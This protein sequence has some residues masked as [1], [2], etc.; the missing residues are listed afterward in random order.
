MTE[1]KE[2]NMKIIK[3]FIPV[4]LLIFIFSC[5]NTTGNQT[6]ISGKVFYQQSSEAVNGAIVYLGK[7]I[8]YDN[9]FNLIE[10]TVT[11]NAGYF[12][13]DAD[14]TEF[15]IYNIYAEKPINKNRDG[16]HTSPVT[17]FEVNENSE[18]GFYANLE[19][20]SMSESSDL[21]GCAVSYPGYLLT[22]Q[23]LYLNKLE[24]GIFTK[25]DSIFTDDGG[26]YS[27]QNLQ[28]GNY[29]ISTSYNFE[30]CFF[31]TS[32]YIFCDGEED[33]FFDPTYLYEYE[34]VDKPAIYIYP[35]KDQKFQVELELHHKTRIIKS[36]PKY[37]NSWQVFVEKSGRI[38]KK[39]DYLFY[40]IA[41]AYNLGLSAGWCCSKENLKDRINEILSQI[42]L[43]ENE[44]REFLDYWLPRLKDHKYYKM[45]PLLNEE[46]DQ[47]VE[48]KITPEPDSILRIFLFFKG[49]KTFENLPEP[50]IPEF[51]RIGTTV[52]EWGGVLM[53]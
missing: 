2:Q 52:V 45:S 40:E 21:S 32:D 43:N 22:N 13:F 10:Q 17:R 33:Y 53:N 1:N 19:L 29:L 42:G 26:L 48:L 34:A 6:G 49:C 28:T 38:D 12:S 3:S 4:F 25:T 27:V 24:Q 39:H 7:S 20:Y 47:Y 36:I 11:N 15:N 31:Y 35:E 8:I 5:E 16:A 41:I 46:I 18:P 37:K 23:K 9:S 44:I 51:K 30:P 14:I 50:E